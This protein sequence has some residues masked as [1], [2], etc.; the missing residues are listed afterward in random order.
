MSSLAS[1]L[2]IIER[3]FADAQD[4]ADYE[5]A[6]RAYNDLRITLGELFME[7]CRAS[8]PESR[9]RSGI[10]FRKRIAE[11]DH[12]AYIAVGK[13]L[14]ETHERH[15][16]RRSRSRSEAGLLTLSRLGIPKK[17]RAARMVRAARLDDQ[18]ERDE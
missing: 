1:R 13:I 11:L 6:S 15:L 5:Q 17:Q 8:P 9:D 18:E 3:A 16:R 7:S 4:I 10:D 14:I 2:K 12:A